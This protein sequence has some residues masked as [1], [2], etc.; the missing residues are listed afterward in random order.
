M[1][2]KILILIQKLISKVCKSINEYENSSSQFANIVTVIQKLK[3][4]TVQKFLP[5]I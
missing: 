5:K 2:T 4:H 3:N 1:C